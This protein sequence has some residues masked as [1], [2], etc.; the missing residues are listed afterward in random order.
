MKLKKKLPTLFIAIAIGVATLSFYAFNADSNADEDYI[1]QP[2]WDNLKVLPKDISKDS[3]TYL[4]K[5]YSASL[6]VKCNFC[7]IKSEADPSKLDFASDGKFE[8]EV[9]RGM[10]KM[11]DDINENYF[12]PHFPDPKP[13]QVYVVNCVLCHRG[14]TKPDKYLA[15]MAEMYHAIKPTGADDKK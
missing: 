13:E 4:M 8:K 9:A 14:T 12:K 11:T 7:H 3:L 1:A 15:S 2:P 6:G 5:S 10:I